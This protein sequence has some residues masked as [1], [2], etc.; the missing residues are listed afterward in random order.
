MTIVV[1]HYCRSRGVF[2]FQTARLTSVSKL[3]PSDLHWGKSTDHVSC[4]DLS[5]PL[6][7]ENV[8]DQTILFGHER[9]M[10]FGLTTTPLQIASFP[11]HKPVFYAKARA[12]FSMARLP[13]VRRLIPRLRSPVSPVS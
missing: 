4:L 10:W 11:R 12:E 8:Y 7:W 6:S 9:L 3:A 5:R 13:Y 1:L 2:C